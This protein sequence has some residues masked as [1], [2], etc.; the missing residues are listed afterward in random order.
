MQEPLVQWCKQNL[1]DLTT[2]DIGPGIHYVQE[3]HPHLI[4]KELAA[5]YQGL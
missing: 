5:W 4:G 2:I 3:D 1:K